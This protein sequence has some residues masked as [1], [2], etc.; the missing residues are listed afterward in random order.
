MSATDWGKV[1]VKYLSD[2]DFLFY[3]E[4]ER[5]PNVLRPT[6]QLKMAKDLKN[7]LIQNG[8]DG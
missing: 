6:T 1:R 5:T 7:T 4:Y 8:E 2:K 3:L